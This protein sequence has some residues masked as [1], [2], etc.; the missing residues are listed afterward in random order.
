MIHQVFN[1]QSIRFILLTTQ[2]LPPARLLARLCLHLYLYIFFVLRFIKSEADEQ[3]NKK[4]TKNNC[5]TC[6]G[7]TTILY[8]V[9]ELCMCL[10][11]YIHMCLKF[12]IYNSHMR[13]YDGTDKI[14]WSALALLVLTIN[15]PLQK[16]KNKLNWR[17]VLFWQHIRNW[18]SNLRRIFQGNTRFG[19]SSY[20]FS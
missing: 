8:I 6:S 7:Y 9:R 19:I 20:T 18:H 5:R 1:E 13:F 17:K 16:K 14:K 4:C 3:R 10:H 12:T 2:S 15:E 11:V